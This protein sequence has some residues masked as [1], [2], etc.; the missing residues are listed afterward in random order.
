MYQLIVNAISIIENR[1][2]VNGTS[3]YSKKESCL[4]AKRAALYQPSG[5]R[6]QPE[7]L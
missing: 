1:D 2:L 3:Q 6:K 4:S 5:G 7:D